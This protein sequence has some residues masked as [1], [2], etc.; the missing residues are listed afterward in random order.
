MILASGCCGVDAV[1]RFT[2]SY[3]TRK[4]IKEKPHHAGSQRYT[5]ENQNLI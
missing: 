1:H 4:S 5:E 2:A 3:G